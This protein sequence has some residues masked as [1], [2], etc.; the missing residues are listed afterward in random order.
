MIATV[1]ARSTAVSCW[2]TS[3]ATGAAA[4]HARARDRVTTRL[5]YL[6]LFMAPQVLVYLYLRERLPS[7]AG[8]R[9][10]GLVRGAL[11]VTFLLFNLPW[12]AVGHRILFD[13]VWGV[14]WIP[15]TGPFVA[16]QLLG[17]VFCGLVVAY[18]ALKGLLWVVGWVE[19]RR[20]GTT[21]RFV[22][23]ELSRAP[24]EQLRPRRCL[25]PAAHAHAALGAAVSTY[26]IWSAYELPRVTRRTLT[27]PDLPSG[28]EGLT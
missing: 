27:F 28:L 23:F 15:F 21:D 10:A 4:R 9:R 6:L 24:E 13:T 22:S 12:L 11:A 2:P 18:V 7:A 26:G 3:G 25:A 1:C 20:V 14:G 16:W 17:W 19:R 8:P 5:I